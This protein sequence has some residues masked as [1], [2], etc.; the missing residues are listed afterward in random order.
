MNAHITLEELL[1]RFSTLERDT[2]LRQFACWVALQTNPS[3][4]SHRNILRTISREL[5][6]AGQVSKVCFETREEF[7]GTATAAGTVGM[8]HAPQS[9]SSFLACYS[10]TDADP[11]KAASKAVNYACRWYQAA[12]GSEDDEVFAQQ[13]ADKLEA[14][15]NQLN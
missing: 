15:W 4:P 10:C 3:L 6:L 14:M 5:E 13:L 7:H 12:N 8:N 1:Q 2:E 11:F 9:A